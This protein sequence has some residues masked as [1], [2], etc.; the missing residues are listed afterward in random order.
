M[1]RDIKNITQW[2]WCQTISTLQSFL[3]KHACKNHLFDEVVMWKIHGR[4]SN[5]GMNC[6]V[7]DRAMYS[8]TGVVKNNALGNFRFIMAISA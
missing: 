7:I 4:S 5:T 1:A 2:F 6:M 8:G 3:Y